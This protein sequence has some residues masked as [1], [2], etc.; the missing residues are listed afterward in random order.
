[1]L[2]SILEELN[3]LPSEAVMVGDGKGDVLMA[4]AA[5]VRPIVVLT[6]QLSQQEAEALGVT[7][8]IQSVVDLQM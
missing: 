3:V 1:M 7:T 8:I 2:L 4:Q 6:G 5:N